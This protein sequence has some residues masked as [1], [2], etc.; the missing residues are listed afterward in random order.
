MGFKDILAAD[1]E[2]VFTNPEEFGESIVYRPK[3]RTARTI[4][5]VVDEEGD[6]PDT[7][8]GRNSAE[9]LDV[10][11]T[12]DSTTGIDQPRFG[13]MVSRVADGTGTSAKWYSYSG[14]KMDVDE[15]A[16]SLRFL[17]NVDSKH[18]GLPSQ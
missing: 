2:N 9:F 14:Q 3:D 17:R 18:G 8:T 13:D 16:W 10:F 7:Q 1:V 15:S 4:N 11:V 5:A 6:F 12:R